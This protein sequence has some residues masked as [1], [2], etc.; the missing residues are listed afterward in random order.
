MDKEQIEALHL[1]RQRIEEKIS[2]KEKKKFLEDILKDKIKKEFEHYERGY[3]AFSVECPKGKHFS[4]DD[5][6]LT[7]IIDG[8]TNEYQCE[9]KSLSLTDIVYPKSYTFTFYKPIKDV[10]RNH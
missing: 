3:R 7:T 2:E 8:V 9:F 1:Q 10:S 6:I 4:I 5:E